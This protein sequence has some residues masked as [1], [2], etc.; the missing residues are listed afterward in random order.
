[1]Q[2]NIVYQAL[3]PN[4][5]NRNHPRVYHAFPV[6]DGKQEW[7]FCNAAPRGGIPWN[8]EE[9]PAL[10]CKRCAKRMARK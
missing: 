4:N 7:A 9:P 3:Y 8:E 10:V 6:V 2:D 1:M 5:F